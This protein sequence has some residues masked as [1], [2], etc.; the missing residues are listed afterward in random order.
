MSKEET[1]KHI[2]KVRLNLLSTITALQ[3]RAWHHD[4]SKLE[5]PEVS[6]FDKVTKDLKG[7]TYGSDE[8]KEQLKTMK[9]FLDHHYANNRH[10]PEF[11]ED[12]ISGM[13]LI[14][15]VEMLMDWWAATERH[16]DGDIYRSIEINQKRFG[17]S[18]EL[19]QIF[20]NTIKEL[21]N[22]RLRKIMEVKNED[23]EESSQNKRN[24]TVSR[25]YIKRPC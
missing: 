22:E 25:F 3:V 19:K 10:H 1:K 5:E 14:D 18:D 11:H 23:S 16:D 13:S 7:L 8:Y 9:P 6:G 24:S 2:D 4:E 17:Y 20:I 12:G 15:I 21:E